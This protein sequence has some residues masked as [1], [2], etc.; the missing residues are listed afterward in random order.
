[1]SNDESSNAW[2]IA[3]RCSCCE[4]A[5][6]IKAL[7]LQCACDWS[8][9]RMLTVSADFGCP[10]GTPRNDAGRDYVPVLV[11][12]RSA[13]YAAVASF[14]PIHGGSIEAAVRKACKRSYQAA[15]FTD[16]NPADYEPQGPTCEMACAEI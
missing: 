14:A 11:P 1:M 12:M 10:A 15:D 6:P 8:P 2:T 3:V 7:T 16:L 4:W 5:R 9:C 13:Q